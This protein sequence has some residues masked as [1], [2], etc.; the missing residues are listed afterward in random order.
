[1]YFKLISTKGKPKYTAYENHYVNIN[2]FS[3]ILFF[4]E[5]CVNK[6]V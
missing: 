6:I 1:M 4:I 3:I 5:T 2:T